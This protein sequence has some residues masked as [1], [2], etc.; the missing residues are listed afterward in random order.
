MLRP[1][2]LRLLQLLLLLGG[3][4]ARAGHAQT[5]PPAWSRVVGFA[6][7]A[8][9][10]SAVSATAANAAG[11]VLVAGHFYNSVTLGSIT[12]TS[13]VRY[14]SDVFVAKWSVA[15]NSFVWAVQ[16]GGNGNDGIGG[17]AV[18]G[19]SVYVAGSFS[20]AGATFGSVGLT[21]RG[22]D[23][24]FVARLTD[25]G[26]SATWDWVRQGGGTASDYASAVAVSG[27]SVYVGGSFS[28]NN[29]AEPASFGS[30]SFVSQGGSDGFLAKLTDPGTGPDAPDFAWAVPVQGDGNDGVDRLAANGISV[31][32]VGSFYSFALRAGSTGVLSSGNLDGFVLKLTDAGSTGSATW[33][34]GLGGTGADGLSAVAVSGSAVYVAG[35]FGSSSLSVDTGAFTTLPN[36]GTQSHDV[37]VARLLDAGSTA[38][39]QWAS[40]L[41]GTGNDTPAAL[42]ADGSTCYLAGYFNSPTLA[43]GSTTLSNVG[44]DDVFVTRFADTGTGPAYAW[45]LPAGGATT[46]AAYALALPVGSGSLYVGGVLHGK[47]TFGTL[48]ATGSGGSPFDDTGFLAAIGS[49][50]PLATASPAVAVPRLGISPNPARATA[51][52]RLPTPGPASLVL[53]DALGRV[54]QSQPVA[55]AAGRVVLNLADLAPGLYL[56]RGSDG[57]AGR[58]VVE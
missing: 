7:A 23:D 39:Y 25:N 4:L 34:Q 11:D 37:V 45:A 43:I 56:L 46:D 3:L 33:M 9:N 6:Q 49:A 21:S 16:A 29:T 53:L 18:R 26:T 15:T 52:V 14:N 35:F 42:L 17:L 38:S 47:S 30:S 31:Y 32:A 5:Q 10:S 20:Q 28:T 12:L 19:S 48:S 41:G 51:T 1:A 58:L 50:A 27:N 22:S 54:V 2:T 40:R 8:G 13:P 24:A 44:R 36:A 55:P 57:S